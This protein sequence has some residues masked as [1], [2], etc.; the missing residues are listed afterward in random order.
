MHF[1]NTRRECACHNLCRPLIQSVV[2]I[3]K[4]D[5]IPTAGIEPSL[6]SGNLTSVRLAYHANAILPYF[7]HVH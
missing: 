5:D 3:K 2:G 1:G 4:Y 7:K 6:I